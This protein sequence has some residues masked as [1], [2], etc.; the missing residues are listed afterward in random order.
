M[1]RG[2]Q[3]QIRPLPWRRP[4]SSKRRTLMNVP[5]T[6]KTYMPPAVHWSLL[7]LDR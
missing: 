3:F 7:E 6:F 1:D 2:D 5:P 4:R